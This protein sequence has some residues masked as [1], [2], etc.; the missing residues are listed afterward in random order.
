M[1]TIEVANKKGLTSFFWSEIL[2]LWNAKSHK[3]PLISY[4]NNLMKLSCR[5]KGSSNCNRF[6][7]RIFFSISFFGLNISVFSTH[8]SDDSMTI[9]ALHLSV[10][11]P[12]VYHLNKYWQVYIEQNTFITCVA[13]YK[14]LI[15]LNLSARRKTYLYINFYSFL[16]S[17]EIF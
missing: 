16:P 7:H 15:F 3:F 14:F 6:L 5:K 2:N 12:D 9:P 8:I 1:H 4:F 17:W 13:K 10:F 11:I